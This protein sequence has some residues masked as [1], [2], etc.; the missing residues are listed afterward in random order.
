MQEAECM[1]PSARKLEDQ[2]AGCWE[3]L[4]SPRPAQGIFKGILGT[5]LGIGL[6]V[7]HIAFWERISVSSPFPGKMSE[8]ELKNR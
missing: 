8:A 5:L 6:E 3:K 4:Q 2:D 7:I 1:G